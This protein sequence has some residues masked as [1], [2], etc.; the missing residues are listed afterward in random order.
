MQKEKMVELQNKLD[1]LEAEKADL[2][3]RND[4]LSSAFQLREEELRKVCPAALLLAPK[5]GN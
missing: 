3:R 2:G 4:M 5:L 1:K